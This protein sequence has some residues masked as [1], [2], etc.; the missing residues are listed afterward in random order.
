MVGQIAIGIAFA[1]ALIGSILYYLVAKGRT[2]YLS[3]AR[4]SAHICI[5]GVIL[6]AGT[7]LYYI[8]NYRFDISYVYEHVSRSLSKPLLFSTF[9]ASQ[10]GSFMLWAL[11]TAIIAIPLM[12]YASR[13]R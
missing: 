12:P 7:L 1:S 9:Y 11:L 4:I 3:A 5:W 2:E 8:F 13:Q 10:E 6:S